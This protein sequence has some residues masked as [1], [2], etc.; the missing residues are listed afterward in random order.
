MTEKAFILINSTKGKEN[1]LCEYLRQRV[2]V[3][4]VHQVTGP[5]NV[6][7]V[8][9]GR[10]LGEIATLVTT[11]IS[12][13]PGVVGWVVHANHV[14]FSGGN[15]AP[16]RMSCNDCMCWCVREPELSYRVAEF[17]TGKAYEAHED[18]HST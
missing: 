12:V 8:I 9:E 10:D 6:V 3:K 5:Y 11:D 18:F 2:Q 16:A 1:E 17:C 7:A 13:A 4:L 15:K 14:L